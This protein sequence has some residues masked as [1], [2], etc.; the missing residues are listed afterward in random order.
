MDW[1]RLTLG[2]GARL[3]LTGWAALAPAAVVALVL[4]LH[5]LA[6]WSPRRAVLWTAP[7]ALAA[8]A[9]LLLDPWLTHR[10]LRGVPLALALF[11]GAGLAVGAVLRAAWPA[12]R[13]RRCASW[14][15]SA[16]PRS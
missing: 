9:G 8:V 14:P 11:G 13:G 3:R 15:H 2:P 12:L 10:L 4:A 6:G 7:W 5:L 1:L 16:W